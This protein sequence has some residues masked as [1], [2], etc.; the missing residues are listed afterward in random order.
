V[1][2]ARGVGTVWEERKPNLDLVEEENVLEKANGTSCH[3][4]PYS[5]DHPTKD[6]IEQD[7]LFS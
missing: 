1:K 4:A 3:H 2:E 5:I 7:I 6:K